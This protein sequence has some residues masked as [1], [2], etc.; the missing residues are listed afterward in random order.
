[1][2]KNIVFDLGGVVV[3]FDP[4]ND[5]ADRFYDEVL[6]KEL[7]SLTFGSNEWRRMDSG[8]LTREQ[9]YANMLEAARKAGHHFEVQA[10]LVDLPADLQPPAGKGIQLRP[11]RTEEN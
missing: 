9:A 7:F 3:G 5:L 8:E 2:Y 1:M 10:I 4:Q 11:W 6:E